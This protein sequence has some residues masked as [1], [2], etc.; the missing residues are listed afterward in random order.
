VVEHC[1]PDVPMHF[2][3]FHPDWKMRD[4]PAT[5]AATL[6]RARQIALANGV[7]YAYT[8]NVHDPA[9]DATV[10]PGCGATVVQR[11]WYELR[12]YHL[13]GSG[14]CQRCGN[15]IAGVFDG[16][17]GTWGRMRLPVRMG[18]RT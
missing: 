14:H 6:T 8:G 15:R 7:R 16:P 5:P 9:G 13:D 3:A 4:V 17:A 1:G 10:C 12:E 11:D 18:E 2:S